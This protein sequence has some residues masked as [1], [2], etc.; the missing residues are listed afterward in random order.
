MADSPSQNSALKQF[1]LH[2][3]VSDFPEKAESIG[4]LKGDLSNITAPPFVLADKSTTE[5]PRYWISHPDIFVAPAS[6][7]NDAKRSLAVLKWFLASLRG[8]QYAGRKPSEG[9]KKPL[10]AFLGELFVAEIGPAGEETRL[11]SE[12]VSHHP[13][14][15]ACYLWNQK[16]G[17]RAEGYTRQEITF[18]GS[19]NIQ[20]IGHA[21]LTVEKYEE[22]YLI[23]LPNV[24]V[25]GILSGGPYPELNGS[26]KIVSSSGYVAEVDF[27]GKGVLGFGGEKNHVKAKIHD[28]DGQ[29]VYIVEG[30]WTE[31][32]IFKDA[33][34]TTIE[35]YDCATASVSEARTAALSDQDPWESR[36]AWRGV[37]EAIHK[38]DMQGVAN[39]KSTLEN[40]QRE[41]RKHS[42]TSEEAWETLFFRRDK[43]H[44]VASRLMDVAGMGLEVEKTKG[45]WRF[46]G[47]KAK[48]L[49]KPWR[50]GLEPANKH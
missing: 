4:T 18:S 15:T 32:L 12:Q 27:S 1:L 47:E 39:A 3:S 26:Y 30:S 38:G 19:V 8:Q 16:H 36:V 31:K 24:K 17:V 7:T 44:A 42:E 23:P 33:S 46:D 50:G 41:M 20:Q 48:G 13:P 37:I 25:K 14:V 49:E 6:E 45:V 10:N 11:V 5:F 40:A 34:G 43:E 9:V 22:D 28:K 29:V 35:T 21:V 2:K